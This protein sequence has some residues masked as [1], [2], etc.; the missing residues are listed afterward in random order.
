[1]VRPCFL[2][3]DR[4]HASSV[5]SRK[6]VIETAK[7]NVVTAYSA[8]EAIETLRKFPAMDGVVVDVYQVEMSCSE[9]AAALKAIQPGIPIIAI[10]G[11]SRDMCEGADYH[12]DSFEPGPLLLLLREIVPAKIAAIEKKNLEL[13]TDRY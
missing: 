9:L 2:V 5:S 10:S 6:L 8:H 7:M 13:E 11:P 4:E 12:V 1:M 3:V